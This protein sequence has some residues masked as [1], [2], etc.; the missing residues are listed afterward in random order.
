L[1]FKVSK[2]LIV[3]YDILS[4]VIVSPTRLEILNKLF[5]SPDG[6]SYNELVKQMT[7]QAGVQRHLD[8]LLKDNIIENK[9]GKYTLSIYG[10]DVYDALG[11][12]ALKVKEEGLLSNL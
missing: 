3:R 7:E 2:D 10:H 5:D 6:L 11:K 12:V 8:V 4:D 1:R 9:S